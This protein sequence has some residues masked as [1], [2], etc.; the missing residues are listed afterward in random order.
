MEDL[1]ASIREFVEIS[2]ESNLDLDFTFSD[3]GE[4]L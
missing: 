1:N 2:S 3:S 4:C